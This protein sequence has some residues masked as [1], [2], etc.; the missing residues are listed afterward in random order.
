MKTH[1]DKLNKRF[2]LLSL[3]ER[4]LILFAGL[5]VIGFPYYTLFW[6]PQ[7]LEQ[8]QQVKNKGQL[9]SQLRAV[10]ASNLELAQ[11]LKTDP[12]IALREQLQVLLVRKES[13]DARLDEQQLGLIPVERMAAVLESMLLD[14]EG[15]QLNRMQSL[16]PSPIL[17]S[18]SEQAQSSFYRHGLRIE[19]QGD[20]FSLLRYL[21]RLESQEQRFLWGSLEFEIIEHPNAQL[22]IELY[23][24]SSAKEFV[25]G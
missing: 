5:V 8:D 4:I 7:Q 13:I 14:S 25:S 17:E 16:K 23:T 22:V 1:W 3:R 11:S 20:Y 24:L 15:V 12:N 18:G 10:Q 2:S 19:L 9:E 21:E 6:E